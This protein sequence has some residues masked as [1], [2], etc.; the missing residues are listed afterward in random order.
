ME[1]MNRQP[2]AR[3]TRPRDYDDDPEFNETAVSDEIRGDYVVTGRNATDN[4]VEAW[5]R[6]GWVVLDGLLGEDEIDAVSEDL[7]TLAPTPQEY[8]ADPQGTVRKW[9]GASADKPDD[10]NWPSGSPGFR[11]SQFRWE[12]LF[13]FR[14]SNS[15]NRMCVNARVVDFARR[16]LGSDDVR[17]YQAGIDVRYAGDTDYEQP[18]HQDSNHSLLPA[19]PESPWWNMECFIYLSDVHSTSAPTHLVRVSDAEETFGKGGAPASAEW[20]NK[21]GEKSPRRAPGPVVMPS[22]GEPMYDL[23]HAATGLRGS[24]LAY[25]PDVWHRGVNFTGPGES[26]FL[27]N[28]SYRLAAVEWVGAH[29]WQQTATGPEWKA[30]VASATPDEL[31]LFGFPQPGHPIWTASLLAETA[32][33]Y[34]GLDI[35]P[36]MSAVSEL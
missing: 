2:F 21:P 18:I 8:H 13:P 31:R 11:R 16:C 34:P 6:D 14:A 24:V 23:Q 17:L 3:V 27:L 32:Q 4:E 19:T 5:R 1:Q 25:R 29:A 33:R 28:V 35:S 10:F 30:F 9:L 12:K 26:R 36:W 7:R 20:T 15:L 22:P